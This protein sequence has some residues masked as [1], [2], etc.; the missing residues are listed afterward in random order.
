M[1]YFDFEK[2]LVPFKFRESQKWPAINQVAWLDS[3]QTRNKWINILIPSLRNWSIRPYLDQTLR[4]FEGGLS[5][6]EEVPRLVLGV[7]TQVASGDRR[8]DTF[9]W[10]LDGR[11]IVTSSD[12]SND[13]VLPRLTRSGIQLW[14]RWLY[15]FSQ[16]CSENSF[17]EWTTHKIFHISLLRRNNVHSPK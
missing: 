16:I 12:E 6:L 9:N 14:L 13:S 3:N 8:T 15:F 11:M 7:D 10:Q 4:Y 17:T 1:N 2:F 5:S